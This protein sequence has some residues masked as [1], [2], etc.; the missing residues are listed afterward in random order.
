MIVRGHT[1]STSGA[2]LAIICFFLPWVSQSCGNEPPR[3]R[4]GW[5]LVTDGDRLVLL[6][7]LVALAVLAL[8][9]LGA[10]LPEQEQQREQAQAR[11]DDGV[12]AGQG[13]A[14]PRY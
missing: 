10:E 12:Q 1:I 9:R 14:S 7:P 8:G 13:A 6:V 4:S 5:E 11:R 3:V 2:A